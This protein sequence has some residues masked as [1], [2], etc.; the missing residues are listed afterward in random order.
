MDLEEVFENW[1]ND[2]KMNI[3]DLSGES[4]KIPLLH[5]KYLRLYSQENSK[6][7]KLE[8]QYKKLNVLKYDYYMGNLNGS[9]ELT[10]LGWEPFLKTVLRADIQKYIEADTDIQKLCQIIDNQRE[11][12]EVLNS[13]MKE[14]MSRNFIIKSAIDFM[15]FQNGV[16]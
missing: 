6:L 8:L 15:K 9:E 11:K 10:K 3:H 12:V 13:I 2:T 4:L 16:I 7:K 1:N 14:I 5:N